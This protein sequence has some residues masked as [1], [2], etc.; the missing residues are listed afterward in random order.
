[1]GAINIKMHRTRRFHLVRFERAITGTVNAKYPDPDDRGYI[2]PEFGPMVGVL[3]GSTVT[4][5]L[6]RLSIDNGA[7]LFVKS[8]DPAAFTVHSPRG[9]AL[10]SRE[11]NE[12]EITGVA[13]GNPRVAKLEV[14]YQSLTGPI[15]HELTVW[16]LT[17]LNVTLVQHKVTIAGAAAP[18]VPAA[19][20]VPSTLNLGTIVPIVRAIWGHY[21]ITFTLNAPVVDAVTFATAGI[22]QWAEEPTL[23]GTNWVPGAINVYTVHQ[24]ETGSTLG[25][26]FSRSSFAGFGMPNPAIVLADNSA[27]DPVACAHALAHEIGHFFTL[28]HPE[29][30]Q[31]PTERE[32]TWC[33]RRLMHNYASLD[34]TANWKDNV[35]YGAGRAGD[36]VTIKHLS[37]Q[38]TDGECTTAR[39]TIGGA[40]GPY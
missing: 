37:Q 25:Y 27:S 38:T 17:P 34:P 12:I 30:M 31:P 28:W 3:V 29:N 32:D 9:G 6:K 11:Y 2:G 5:R 35:G 8:S 24:I 14:H 40:A 33:R 15:I 19:A 23:L 18:G 22:V 21:G 26:G 4:L 13:G 1:M 10:R 16:V 36:F 39:G 7:P 20:G